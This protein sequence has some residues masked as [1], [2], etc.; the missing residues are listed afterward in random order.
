M[1]NSW[2]IVLIILILINI[3]LLFYF[4]TPKEDKES[5]GLVVIDNKKISYEEGQ[6]C[7]TTN[8]CQSGLI[9]CHKDPAVENNGICT[10]DLS[11]PRP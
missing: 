10:N 8:E 7:T 1:K 9:C 11:C 4:L 5:Q 3:G 2:I 6:Q